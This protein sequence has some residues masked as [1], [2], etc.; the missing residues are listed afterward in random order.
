MRHTNT[1]SNIVAE[2]A[3]NDGPVT[4]AS[5]LSQSLVNVD[6]VYSYLIYA[7]YQDHTLTG[8]RVEFIVSQHDAYNTISKA[9][10]ILDICKLIDDSY[11]REVQRYV[12]G[13]KQPP[14]DIL[15]TTLD[16][17]V[18]KLA[19]QQ[20]SYWNLEYED[21]CQT[22]RLVICTLYH[23]GYYIHKSLI[24]RAFI[25]EVL[26]SIRKDRYKPQIVSI[27]EPV[28]YDKEGKAQMVAD[29]IED[30]S[31]EDEFNEQYDEEEHQYQLEQMREIVIDI[32]G[33]RQY[34]QLVR[35]Y[36]NKMT[37]NAGRKQTQKIRMKLKEIGIS[38]ELFR[39]LQ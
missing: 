33:R 36:G 39:R 23:K 29:T 11:S 20:Q 10:A 35:E 24:N 32:I 25:N 6:E 14:L 13:Y 26:L 27:D 38:E 37:T 9:Q 15:L 19:R 31:A 16:P 22:C 30:P 12:I 2:V 28:A 3:N 34:D 4:P 5:V 7:K 21:L 1:L 8:W 18:Q 17:L